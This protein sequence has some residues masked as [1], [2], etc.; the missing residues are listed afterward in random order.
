MRSLLDA[1][2]VAEL[3]R[4]LDRLTPEARPEWGRMSAH[5]MVCHL[6]DAC[7]V[8]LGETAV[9]AVKGPLR[10]GPLRWFVVR[11]M[12]I[13][14]ARIQTTPEYKATKPGEWVADLAAL[15][16][17]SDRLAEAL[18]DPTFTPG[19]HPVFG[20]LS[21]SDWARLSWRHSDHHLR[22]FGV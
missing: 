22:Q 21:A 5:Q 10:S 12:P 4:R 8:G 18:R 3:H 11:L 2:T 19:E 6:A 17:I 16:E 1:R 9:T 15:H 14:K 20:W 13:P 7:R